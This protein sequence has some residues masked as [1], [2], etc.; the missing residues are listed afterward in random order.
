MG[1]FGKTKR[2][3][4]REFDQETLVYKGHENEM[5]L[6][7]SFRYK[8]EIRR[9]DWAQ[10]TGTQRAEVSKQVDGCRAAQPQAQGTPFSTAPY[11]YFWPHSILESDTGPNS[12]TVALRELI[13]RTGPL[14]PFCLWDRLPHLSN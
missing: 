5:P 4:K 2:E 11:N 6:E 1:T 7:R 3:R 8:L 14:A 13:P 12:A 9:K 10:L